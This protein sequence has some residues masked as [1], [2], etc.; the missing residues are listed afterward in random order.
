M[1]N[2][3]ILSCQLMYISNI[4]DVFVF[5]FSKDIF[6]VDSFSITK[7]LIQLYYVRFW[8]YIRSFIDPYFLVWVTP[9]LDA[10]KG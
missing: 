4:I 2:I 6:I 7:E 3:I 1:N 9:P 5:I 8:L 10:F